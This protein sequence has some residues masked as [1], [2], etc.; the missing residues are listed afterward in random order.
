[1]C[2]ALSGAVQAAAAQDLLPEAE[3]RS[4]TAVWSSLTR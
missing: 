1:M 4:L 3:R 2:N